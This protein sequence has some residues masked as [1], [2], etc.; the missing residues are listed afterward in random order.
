MPNPFDTAVRHRERRIQSRGT[1]L[2]AGNG[3][4]FDGILT[5][6]SWDPY[7]GAI[8][9]QQQAANAEGRN[10]RLDTS[11]LGNRGSMMGRGDGEAARS[12]ALNTALS[13]MQDDRR[14]REQSLRD[15]KATADIR[16]AQAKAAGAPMEDRAA[17]D[18]AYA[19]SRTGAGVMPGEIVKAP[20]GSY[21]SR[22]AGPVA[23]PR[24][25][26][27]ANLPGHLQ[28]QPKPLTFDKPVPMMVGGK[29]QFVREG[30]D[31]QFYG[32]DRKPIDPSALAPPDTGSTA[33]IWVMRNGKQVRISENEY[34]PGDLPASTREQGRPVTS[35]D[36]S[37]LADFDTSKDELAAVRAAISPSDSTGIVARIGATIPFV[38]QIS[39]WGSD[40]KKRQAVIDRVKQVIGKTLEGGVLRKEDEAKY[41]KILPNIGD[42]PDVATAKLNGLDSAIDKRKQRRLDALADAG[43]ETSRFKE[44]GG[45][46]DKDSEASAWLKA[47][48][49]P[50]TPANR[51]AW[52]AR[53]K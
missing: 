20:D 29:R 3:P 17:I 51:A 47:N 7:Y 53:Q 8:Y 21:S 46:G 22:G 4:G 43:Y 39:G 45:S 14:A 18:R 36:A 38:T 49:A 41:E 30:S 6:E 50:D 44:R 19:L 16:E 13:D 25:V 40:A 12:F 28:P 27:Q 34:Q 11:G 26:M 32:M 35:G 48:G 1:S 52:I 24:A 5:D 2:A 9:E 31:G 33:K 37:D 15:M 23:D 42:A 10:V